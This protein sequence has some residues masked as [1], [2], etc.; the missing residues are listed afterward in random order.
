MTISTRIYAEHPD[1]AL[2]HT[3]RTLPDIRVGVLSDAGTDPVTE[4]YMFW[5]EAPDFDAVDEA[6]ATDPT[7]AT[8]SAVDETAERRTY[9]ISYT[10]DAKLLTPTVLDM[11]GLTQEARSHANGWL[12][13]LQ[14]QDH[15]ALVGLDEFA[16]E[17]GIHLEILDL[18]QDAQIANR[19]NY[20]LTDRQ[21]EALVAAYAHGY[22]DEPRQI[23]LEELASILGISN[24]AVSGRLNRGSARLI[25]DILIDDESD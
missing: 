1:L 14:F 5:I 17:H 10:S 8:V 4:G 22:Y 21:I 15:E 16:E 12:L 25:E 7:V 6:L 13:Q 20:G 19:L 18:Q 2:A 11:G 24:T 9:R 23:S 3:I